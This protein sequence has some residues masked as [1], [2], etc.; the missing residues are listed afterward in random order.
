[1]DFNQQ[2]WHLAKLMLEQH[3]QH[4]MHGARAVSATLQDPDRYGANTDCLE[5]VLAMDF[6]LSDDGSDTIH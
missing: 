1:M 6:L 2:T 5:I 3:G 4:A